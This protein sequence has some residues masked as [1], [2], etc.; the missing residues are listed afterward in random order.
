MEEK[1]EKTPEQVAA[2]KRQ[3]ALAR[4]DAIGHLGLKL[5]MINNDMP[6][7][8]QMKSLSKYNEIPTAEEIKG[9]SN[10]L[11]S[12]RLDFMNRLYDQF[13]ADNPEMLD[14]L[15][16]KKTDN[17]QA[18]FALLQILDFLLK[19]SDEDG[20]KHKANVLAYY[21]LLSDYER[22]LIDYIANNQRWDLTINSQEA[23]SAYRNIIIEHE[24]IVQNQGGLLGVS[25]TIKEVRENLLDKIVQL[26]ELGIDDETY[27]RVVSTVLISSYQMLD[28][29]LNQMAGGGS[30]VLA[31][32]SHTI[33]N[34]YSSEAIYQS[35]ID[36][37]NKITLDESQSKKLNDI[38]NLLKLLEKKGF[39]PSK[40]SGSGC[41]V[42]LLAI[43]LPI[44]CAFFFS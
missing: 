34:H 13:F 36:I 14:R 40:S 17:N 2:E 9:D 18:N 11:E 27:N 10:K 35:I 7:E 16:D 28:Y 39:A 21:T 44:L 6:I 4:V 29:A 41:M 25:G 23:F 38:K 20:S 3:K 8:E 33:F 30:N 19:S 5:G 15:G 1:K 24:S 26:K 12:Y 32:F 22:F 43:V 31:I 42:V 37:E